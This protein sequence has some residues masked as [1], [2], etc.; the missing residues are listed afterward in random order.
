MKE[1]MQLKRNENEG[2]R[3][4]IYETETKEFV[5]YVIKAR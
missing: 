5:G 2:E 1:N 4:K 3:E